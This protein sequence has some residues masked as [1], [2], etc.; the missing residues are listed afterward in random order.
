MEK[1]ICNLNILLF[2][3]MLSRC[4][5]AKLAKVSPTTITRALNYG[6]ISETTAKKIIRGLRMSMADIM[7][8]RSATKKLQKKSQKKKLL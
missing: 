3:R 2:D 6:E 4:E 8:Y 1:F 7:K 5:L